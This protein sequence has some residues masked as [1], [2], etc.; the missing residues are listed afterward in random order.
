M[1]RSQPERV[2]IGDWRYEVAKDGRL[3]AAHLVNGIVFAEETLAADA[4]GPHLARALSQVVA[5]W[6]AAF[7]PNIDAARRGPQHKRRPLTP[8]Y[9]FNFSDSFAAKVC[10]S[11]GQRADK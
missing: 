2:E 8:P 10:V 3:L 4:V 7:I 6:G 9:A 1:F 11:P 5:A